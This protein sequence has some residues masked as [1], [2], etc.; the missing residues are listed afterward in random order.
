M[1]GMTCAGDFLTEVA[2]SEMSLEVSTLHLNPPNFTTEL[3]A[4]ELSL[5]FCQSK[6]SKFL[7]PG[8]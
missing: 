5:L 4:F 8:K 1:S 2:D 3:E 6:D 7:S